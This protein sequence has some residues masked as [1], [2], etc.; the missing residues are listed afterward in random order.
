MKPL[1]LLSLLFVQASIAQIITI[2]DPVFK[3]KLLQADIGQEIAYS[4]ASTLPIYQ[5]KIDTNNNGEIE[6]PEVLPIKAL[7]LN[8][9]GISDLTGIEYFINLENLQPTF[10]NLTAINVSTLTNLKRLFLFHNQITSINVSNLTQLVDIDISFNSLTSIDLS[11][12]NNLDILWCRNNPNLTYI[13]IKNNR[14]QSLTPTS[15]SGNRCWYNVPSLITVCADSSEITALQQF[16]TTCGNS[17]AITITTTCAM[18][19]D[20]FENTLYTVY[21]NPSSDILTISSK[22]DLTTIELF[23]VQLR[24]IK[25]INNPEKNYIIDLSSFTKGCYFLKITSSKGSSI[26]KVFKE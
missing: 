23:D 26:K 25:R 2:P 14:D 24:L 18:A 6:V 13:N 20:D 4:N 3:A 7:I 22:N 15:G 9:C 5:A 21:P 19:T 1:A 12:N 11:T 10:N 8:N 16:F 17:A